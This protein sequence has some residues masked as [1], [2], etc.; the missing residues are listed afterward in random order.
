MKIESRDLTIDALLSGHYFF[1][2]RFQRPYSWEE[3]NII[4]FWNDTL[5]AAGESYFIGSMVVFKSGHPS[6]GVVDGQQ[7]LTTITI[8]LCAIRDAFKEI[9]DDDNALGLQQFI[10]RRT[11]ENKHKFV[12]ETETSFPYFQEHILKFDAPEINCKPGDEETALQKAENIFKSKISDNILEIKGNGS[13]N[14]DK[15]LE[16]KKWLVRLRD[17]VLNLTIILISLDNEEN[18]YLIFETLNTR[19]KD[20]SL[21]DLL[22]NLFTRQINQRGDVDH[23]KIKW[24]NVLTTLAD[25]DIE[26]P[27]DT[28]IVQSWAS[29][30]EAIPVKQA[31]PKLKAEI[32]RKTANQHLDYFERDARLYR[33]AFEPSYMW[34][35]TERTASN[36]LSALRLFKVAQP[37]PALL[38]LVRA[39][40]D[41]KIKLG[42][43]I[44]ALQAI[45]NFHFS[46]TAITSSRSSGGISGMYS[47]F[48]RKLFEA[49]GS[50][51]AAIE[52][53]SL[54]DK[55]RQRK[56]NI[57]EFLPKFEGTIYTKN[58]TKQRALI[59]YSLLK[60]QSIENMTHRGSDDDLTIEHLYPQSHIND[61]F[62]DSIVGQFGNLILVDSQTNGTLKDKNFIDK[63]K[64]LID[65]G[66]IIPQEYMDANEITPEMIKSYTAKR[67]EIA[68]SK[69][70]NI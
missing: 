45:E 38:S 42:K 2:P 3:E 11:K 59:K 6:L 9:G 10:E 13:S 52:I 57:Q 54:I 36:S 24:S 56:P 37:A 58:H 50:N 27:P 64:I 35:K 31:F 32:T 46:F 22:K 21:S 20:L 8:L 51:E 39:Y 34:D 44:E 17:T 15:T 30:Y 43:L 29:R 65:N 66:Y 1:I 55:L 40:R 14:I 60:I 70:W 41:E 63:K 26:L 12:L 18:A 23:A 47:S 61:Q 28:F 33:S 5:N 53:R 4:D 49:K 62:T 67:A 48:G 69:G 7:R 19:G 25:A 68:H 16:Q